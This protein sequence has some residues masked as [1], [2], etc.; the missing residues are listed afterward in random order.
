[1]S[2]E[3]KPTLS[4]ADFNASAK[5]EN[6]FEFAFLDEFG[7]ET[8][9]KIKVIGDQSTQVKR[10]INAKINNKRK[11]EAFLTEKGRKVPLDDIEDLIAEN[12]DMLAACIVGWSGIVEEYTPELARQALEN[13]KSLIEQ[14]KEASENIKNFS[15][16]R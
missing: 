7:E 13:N 3:T 4:L 9:W 12:I 10:T 15:V 1:M 8:P 16:G 14:V 2:N 6:A 5:C 11:Q